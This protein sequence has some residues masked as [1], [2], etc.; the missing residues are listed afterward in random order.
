MTL[1]FHFCEFLSVKTVSILEEASGIN[2]IGTPSPVKV[3]LRISKKVRYH[4]QGVED[5]RELYVV[6]TF[7]VQG[8]ERKTS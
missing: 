3:R 1:G 7:T 4:R 5:H 8:T 6:S 2:S